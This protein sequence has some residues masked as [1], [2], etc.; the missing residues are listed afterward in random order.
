MK[1]HEKQSPK[2]FLLLNTWERSQLAW[3]DTWNITTSTQQMMLRFWQ[4]G[5]IMEVDN[6]SH[7]GWWSTEPSL[8]EKGYHLQVYGHFG[9]PIML[10]L[11][12]ELG[13]SNRDVQIY[14][15]SQI[16]EIQIPVASSGVF[17]VTDL[18]KYST[19]PYYWLLLLKYVFNQFVNPK[20]QGVSLLSSDWIFLPNLP[21]HQTWKSPPVHETW[22][23]PEI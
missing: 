4:M 9:R 5:G 15:P 14:I 22:Y 8:W 13:R 16:P 17:W 7:L 23:T 1:G 21:V 3:L 19:I 6:G 20:H 12:D 18:K 10:F 2:T 11:E